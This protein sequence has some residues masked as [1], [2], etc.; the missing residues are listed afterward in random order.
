MQ[1]P[2]KNKPSEIFFAG[3]CAI[4]FVAE[5]VSGILYQRASVLTRGNA[6][7]HLLYGQSAIL[8]AL[9][10]VGFSGVFIGYLLRFNR[11]RN[12]AFALIFL[13]WLCIVVG[14]LINNIQH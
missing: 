8:L 2:R 5:A 6:P 4:G 11:W 1:R 14:V 3:I 7:I 10:Y 13:L 12:L 9:V